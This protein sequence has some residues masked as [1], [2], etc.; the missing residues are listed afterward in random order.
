MADAT[1]TYVAIVRGEGI[2][3]ERS[4]K[5]EGWFELER[6]V[7]NE[8]GNYNNATTS[9]R[10]LAGQGNE[11]GTLPRARA[12]LVLCRPKT[13]RWHQIRQH[14]A[15]RS[16]SHPILGD[17]TH[18]DNTEN[19]LWKEKRNM[20]GE[21]TCLHLARIDLPPTKVCPSGLTVSCPLA[22]DMLQMLKDHLP[23]LV[24]EAGPVLREEGLYLW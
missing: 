8:N 6:P 14:L 3:K 9:F 10:F 13:G 15:G 23:G 20:P 7:K 5:D 2:L 16:L 4:L 11:M 18:G 24:E 12:S 17:T 22:P 21:R 1:K 19:S